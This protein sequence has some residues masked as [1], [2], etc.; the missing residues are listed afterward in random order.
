MTDISI[1]TTTRTAGLL[2]LLIIVAG[3]FSVLFVRDRLII[4]GDP[5]ATAHQIIG[6][7]S[8]WRAG[9]ASDLVMHLCDIPVMLIIYVLLRPV[10]RRIALLALL[11]NVVQTAVLAANKLNLVAAL[12]PL[13]GGAYLKTVDPQIL[14]TLSYLAIRLHDIG[15]GVGLLFFGMTLLANGY[16]IRKSGYL[17]KV[18]GTLLQIAGGC[19]LISNFTL[20]LAPQA[21]AQI[22]LWLMLPCF[23]AELTFALWLLFKGVNEAEW[24]LKEA[25][26]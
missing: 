17:P 14:Y 12:L 15:F 9:I 7:G 13:S 8:L 11:F 25:T 24:K 18:I 5:A 4:A 6:H 2:Y 22:G 20:L 16:L 23:L 21:A 3:M 1:K 26:L 19:Y 10:S